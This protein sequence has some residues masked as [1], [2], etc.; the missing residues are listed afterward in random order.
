MSMHTYGR[1]Y[2]KTN[3]DDDD[4]QMTLSMEIRHDYSVMLA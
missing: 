3:A 1:T 4:D 2:A